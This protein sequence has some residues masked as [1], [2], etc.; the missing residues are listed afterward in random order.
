MKV[1][2][3]NTK[4]SIRNFVPQTFI[5]VHAATEALVEG[6]YY[7]ANNFHISN[8]ETFVKIA[9]GSSSWA[10]A[11]LPIGTYLESE[12]HYYKI[13]DSKQQVKPITLFDI[14]NW[15]S[16]VELNKI[17]IYDN[18][19]LTQQTENNWSCFS[20]E[21]GGG[22]YLDCNAYGSGGSVYKFVVLDKTTNTYTTYYSNGASF[23]RIFIEHDSV[24]YANNFI[25][26]NP[27]MFCAIEL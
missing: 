9:T 10:N 18:G 1:I 22:H 12:G 15:Q 19:T 5:H 27:N 23:Q 21:V 3:N 4:L 8:G 13:I 20:F 17:Y 24:I 11:E 16:V 2:L 26:R 6:E 25:L 14:V 7:W